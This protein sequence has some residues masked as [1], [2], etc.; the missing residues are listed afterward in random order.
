MKMLHPE[1]V[2]AMARDPGRRPDDA[3]INML[4]AIQ[5]GEMPKDEDGCL[6]A[7][8]SWLGFY[9]YIRY[10]SDRME[11]TPKGVKAIEDHGESHE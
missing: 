3:E 9:G 7:D 1:I 4:R 6:D 8:L 2:M 11:L 10:M 5:V